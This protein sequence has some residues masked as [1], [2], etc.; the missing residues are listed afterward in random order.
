MHETKCRIGPWD[1]DASANELCRGGA[2]G[3]GSSIARRGCSSC[4]ATIAVRW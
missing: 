4:S 1:F 3:S 2:I